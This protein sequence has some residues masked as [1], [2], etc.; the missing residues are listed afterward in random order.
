MAGVP[1]WIPPIQ[2][3]GVKVKII[4]TEEFF[5]HMA[6]GI[7]ASDQVIK[8][9]PQMVRKFVRAAL[10][11]MKD[12]I[13][14]PNKS[15][16]EFISFVPEWK[17]KERAIHFALDMYAKSVYPGQKV[18]GEVN[19]ERIVRLQEFYVSKNIIQKAAP[20]DELFTN[21]FIAPL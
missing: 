10:R 11:G 17:G 12:I 3:T 7:A 8:E 13:D 14:D 1:D 21:E 5:P 4:P 19:R 18:I 9:K 16:E 15:A 2:A 20:V 6:Q